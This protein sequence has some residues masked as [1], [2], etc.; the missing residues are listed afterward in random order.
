MLG[1][2]A[3]TL[4]S[5]TDTFWIGLKDNTDMTAAVGVVFPFCSFIQAL[6]FWFGYGSG[7]TMARLIG[8][9]NHDE[10]EKTA[11][12]GVFLAAVSGIFLAAVSVVFVQPVSSLLGGSASEELL[13]CTA[14]Y[15]TVIC[16][17]IPFQMLSTTVYN[18]LRLCGNIKDGMIGM[19][20]GMFG[21]LFLDP[22]FILGFD[23]GITGA[24]IAST[25][26]QIA[27]CAVLYIISAK[28]GNIPMRFFSFD[29]KNKRMYHILL[30][31]APN[32]SRQSITSIASILLNNAAVPYGA[33]LIAAMTVSS[34]VSTAAY[35]MMIGF[36]QGFQ[37][38]C[39][40]NYGAKQYGRVKNAFRLT[41]TIGTI[42][43]TAAGILLAVFAGPL[44]AAFSSNDPE[45]TEKAA[46]L[47]RLQCISFPF[48][49]F[50]AV[51][52]MYMQNIGM[53][54]RSLLISIMRQGIVFIPLLFILPA[55]WGEWGI[56]VL[57]P[58]A[59][60]LSFLV[61]VGI[62]LKVKIEAVK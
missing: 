2:L 26:G 45:V 44:T 20:V 60:I 56:F 28:H 25:I 46:L 3:A 58:A 36:G 17:G 15:L 32:F 29:L 33:S 30:G 39:A 1:M 12:L 27:S 7:N 34:R 31:G 21:N 24:G 16:I 14:S 9:N 43:L 38:I 48:L 61:S 53:Y 5:L 50:Y 4:Y 10:A 55:I 42:F 8:A 52:G 57:Q 62:I 6:G 40:I 47:V 13:D 59:D 18:Q 54:I 41:V 23:M 22:L 35:L 37:P 49:P 51:S 11:S 19:G